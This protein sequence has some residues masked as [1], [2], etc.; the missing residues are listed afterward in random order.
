LLH[1][2][3]RSPRLSASHA[4]RA[5]RR[6]GHENTGSPGRIIVTNR[7]RWLMPII[8][9]PTGDRACWVDPPGP[10]RR[11]RLLGRSDEGARVGMLNLYIA[12]VQQFI[13]PFWK[14]AKLSDFQLV[15]RHADR[16]DQLI[17]RL[18]SLAPEAT[19][20]ALTPQILEQL[21]A[22]R[23]ALAHEADIG[24]IHPPTVEWVHEAD[25]EKVPRTGK[26]RRVV[27]QRRE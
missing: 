11:F 21:R 25:L 10:R 17:L 2:L 18:A 9:Y 3:S 12:D 8:R 26:L 4:P 22:Q 7:A 14:E 15:I 6:L 24:A 5:D 16:R 23:P 19:R 27:D 1:T 20:S 13:A